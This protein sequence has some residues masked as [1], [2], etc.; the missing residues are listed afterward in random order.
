MLH[1]MGLELLIQHWYLQRKQ[2]WKG[3]SQAPALVLSA[4]QLNTAQE[5]GRGLGNYPFIIN[6]LTAL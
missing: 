4:V 3:P 5:Y 2:R 1:R 6:K